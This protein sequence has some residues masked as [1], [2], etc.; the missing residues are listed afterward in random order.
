[1]KI[2]TG[3]IRQQRDLRDTAEARVVPIVV[4]SFRETLALLGVK[5]IGPATLNQY[6]PPWTLP[7]LRRNEIMIGIETTTLPAQ[8]TTASR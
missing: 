6:N 7:F 8:S 1:M 4:N 5:T 2:Q 3:H